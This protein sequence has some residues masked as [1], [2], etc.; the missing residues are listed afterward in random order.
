[1][2]TLQSG[3][4]GDDVKNW[5]TFLQGKGL[6][7][8]PLDGK[9]GGQCVEATRAFQLAHQLK[10]DGVA[11]NKTLGA[12][13]QEGLELAPIDTP[14]PNGPEDGVTSINDA[15]APPPPPTTAVLQK[16]PDP[17]VITKHAVGVKPC[18]PNPPPPVG[19]AYWKGS[20]P[21]LAGKFAVKVET[22][23][24]DFPMG[25][26]V[27]TLIDDKPVAAR[28]EWHDYQGK[29]GAHGVFRGT[30]LFRPLA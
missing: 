13:M 7:N 10:A 3:S 30:S 19:W 27:Q 26:F 20:V 17:R 2:R 22:T 28:V 23:P 21:D 6:Y 9:F 4:V 18:P 16:T 15:W 25:S 1:M 8:G 11:G 12:A 5:Q 24:G 14:L 29:T